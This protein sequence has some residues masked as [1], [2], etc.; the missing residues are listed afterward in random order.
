MEVAPPRPRNM[1]L[2][3]LR[4]LCKRMVQRDEGNMRGTEDTCLHADEG[5]IGIVD[6]A[7]D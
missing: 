6:C 4:G 3:V 5:A 1:V 2:P 7:I